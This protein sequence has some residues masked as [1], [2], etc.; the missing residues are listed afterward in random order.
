MKWLDQLLDLILMLIDTPDSLKPYEQEILTREWAWMLIRSQDPFITDDLWEHRMA[1]HADRVWQALRDGEPKRLRSVVSDGL[2]Q[3]LLAQQAIGRPF[4]FISDGRLPVEALNLDVIRQDGPYAIAIARPRWY[5][6]PTHRTKSWAV[7]AKWFYIRRL[8]GVRPEAVG[9]H[10]PWE[11]SCPRCGADLEL[12]DRV[13]CMQCGAVVNSGEHDW[14]LCGISEGEHEYEIFDIPG[15]L[16]L[17]QR[18]PGFVPEIVE[19]RAVA[20][21]WSVQQGVSEPGFLADGF[22]PPAV[23]SQPF[24]EDIRLQRIEIGTDTDRLQM[25]VRWQS[26]GESRAEQWTFTRSAQATTPIHRGMNSLGCQG[27]GAPLDALGGCGYCGAAQDLDEWR[28]TAIAPHTKDPPGYHPRRLLDLPGRVSTT[29]FGVLHELTRQ[30]RSTC[31]VFLDDLGQA[32]GIGKR[33]RRQLYRPIS[34]AQQLEAAHQKLLLALACQMFINT[35]P[36]TEPCQ[37]AIRDLGEAIG[38]ASA[39]IDAHIATSADVHRQVAAAKTAR[40][41]RKK[42]AEAGVG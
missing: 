36:F 25:R 3:S 1:P 33:R 16:A 13:R 38:V 10:G 12:S 11:Q 39:E 6:D 9:G 2:Y 28:L 24:L 21:F 29:L 27:C 41:A 15:L 19:D 4:E 31:I 32:L 20:I 35:T 7:G 30:S 26:D 22:Q 5:R 37:A 23:G 42:A 14:I 17:R 34:S 18:D 8:D 40:E